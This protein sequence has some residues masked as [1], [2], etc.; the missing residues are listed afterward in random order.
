MG[1]RF[2]HPMMY[3][4]GMVARSRYPP[5]K[6]LCQARQLA[7]EPLG[8]VSQIHRGSYTQLSTGVYA[9]LRRRWLWLL[10]PTVWKTPVVLHEAA[11]VATHMCRVIAIMARARDAHDEPRSVRQLVHVFISARV[12]QY[13]CR[14]KQPRGS[15]FALNHR[16]QASR[17]QCTNVI[18]LFCRLRRDT[19]WLLT[20]KTG[21]PGKRS[22]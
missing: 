9:A 3:N 14:C 21:Y 6:W 7:Q 19:N 10:T 17:V 2:A 4:C 13:R 18:V 16:V 11:K 20:V 22:A 5:I 15:H 12:P 8:E 1:N